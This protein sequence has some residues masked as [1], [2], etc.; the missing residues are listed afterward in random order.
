MMSR[1][2]KTEGAGALHRGILEA[3]LEKRAILPNF[4]VDIRDP[5]FLIGLRL[6][7]SNLRFRNF[8]FEMGFCPISQF[9]PAGYSSMLSPCPKRAQPCQSLLG[10]CPLW[11]SSCPSKAHLC[12]IWGGLCQKEACLCPISGRVGP[13][14]AASCPKPAR[15][16]PNLR[17]S[18]PKRAYHCPNTVS[19]AY[20]LGFLSSPPPKRP[21]KNLPTPEKTLPTPFPASTTP[22]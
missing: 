14:W 6:T 19:R 18:C 9:P 4:N 22:S 2:G 13:V 8:G 7:E 17:T 20:C 12:P 16:R 1:V 10:S 21:P 3:R 5:K 15:H 11:A